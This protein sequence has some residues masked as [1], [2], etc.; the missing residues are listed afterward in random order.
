MIKN[1]VYI[2]YCKSLCKPIVFGVFF[3]MPI[4]KVRTP[5]VLVRLTS[6]KVEKERERE[7]E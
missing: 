7:I 5:V 2:F 3:W 1:I 6:N 4:T